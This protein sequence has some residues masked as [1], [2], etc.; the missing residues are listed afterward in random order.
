[1]SKKAHRK[2]KKQFRTGICPLCKKFFHNLTEHHIHKKAVFG[3]DGF[4]KFICR[5][6]HDKVEN[7]ISCKENE[8]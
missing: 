6:C 8:I 4:T 3:D 5:L 2:K 7:E 1:M